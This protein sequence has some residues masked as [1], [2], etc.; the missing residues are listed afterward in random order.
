MAGGIVPPAITR[1]CEMSY[2]LLFLL[3]L[4]VVLGLKVKIAFWRK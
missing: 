2:H 4:V 1:R 3:T